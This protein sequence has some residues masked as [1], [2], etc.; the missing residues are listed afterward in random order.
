MPYTRTSSSP[1]QIRRAVA[2]ALAPENRRLVVTRAAKR[3]LA[4]AEATYRSITGRDPA[5]D[6]IIDGQRRTS[7]GQLDPDQGEIRMTHSR[8]REALAWIHE[9]LVANSPR[10]T[11][12]YAGAHILLAD[13]KEA[14]P[15]AAPPAERYVFANVAPYARKI[16]GDQ[17]RVG[18]SPK[19]RNGVYQVVAVMA[20]RR[21]GNSIDVGFGWE[22]LLLDYI[23]GEHGFTWRRGQQ[24][25]A[26]RRAGRRLERQ[27]RLPVIAVV[28]R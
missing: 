28:L 15:K 11:G 1:E 19:A 10:L 26:M 18:Q 6:F 13:G 14:D 20:D 7:L 3:E 23:A 4:Q 25:D 9:Q 8:A 2:F 5:S 16:E 24:R 12:A 22:S 27:T 17:D 21:F